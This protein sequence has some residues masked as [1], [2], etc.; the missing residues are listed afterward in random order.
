MNLIKIKSKNLGFTFQASKENAFHENL[1]WSNDSE[2]YEH[3]LK[4]TS[5]LDSMV[6][7]EERSRLKLKDSIQSAK[8]IKSFWRIIEHLI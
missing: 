6:V 3:L 5:G 2:V 4:L 1:E 7:G 8:K